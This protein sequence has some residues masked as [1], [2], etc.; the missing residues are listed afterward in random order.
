[1]GVEFTVE[2][3]SQNIYTQII[4]YLVKNCYN[5]EVILD[6]TE[7]SEIKGTVLWVEKGQLK[8][9]SY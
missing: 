4:G 5:G 8:I 7:I 2:G 3:L 1:M 6:I 9:R